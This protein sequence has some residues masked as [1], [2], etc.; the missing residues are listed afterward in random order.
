MPKPGTKPNRGFRVIVMPEAGGDPKTFKVSP[1]ALRV[2][3]VSALA[4]V[5]AGALTAVHWSRRAQAAGELAE[6]NELWQAERVRGDRLHRRVMEL[7]ESWEKAHHL[8]VGRPDTVGVGLWLAQADGPASGRPN[9]PAT[10]QPDAQSWTWPLAVSGYM[11]QPLVENADRNHPGI[12]IAVPTGS[13][14]LAAADGTVKEAAE[15]PGYGLFVQIDHGNGLYSLYGHASELYVARGLQVRRGEVVAM[16]GSTG[17]STAP[18]LHFE[19][20]RHGTLVDPQSMVVPP[21]Q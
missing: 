9:V 19:I 6:L 11:T 13:Y 16:S 7:E 5:V 3:L 2:V 20:V 14:I 10:S 8:L 12:D 15:D 17:N 21:P 18:H 4:L 1:R